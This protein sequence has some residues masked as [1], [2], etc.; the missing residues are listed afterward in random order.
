MATAWWGSGFTVMGHWHNLMASIRRL[1]AGDFSAR[2]MVP[3]GDNEFSHLAKTFNDMAMSLEKRAREVEQ[4]LTKIA[5]L[6]RM[7]EILSAVNSAIL[8]IRDKTE[9]RQEVCR[10]AVELGRFPLV[11]MGEVSDQ[12]MLSDRSGGCWTRVD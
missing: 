5:R 12:V 8:R 4:H 6:N 1:K 11:W 10:I 3:P 2:V 7:Y 9:L